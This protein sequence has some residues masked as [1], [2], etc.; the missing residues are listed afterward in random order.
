MKQEYT[1]VSNDKLNELI[2]RVN[3]HLAKGWSLGGN[4]VMVNVTRPP[5]ISYCLFYQP[6]IRTVAEEMTA[7]AAISLNEW[8]AA[9][10]QASQASIPA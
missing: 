7:Q 9:L 3:E 1:V 10:C 8:A 6:M 5:S 2:I 4:L